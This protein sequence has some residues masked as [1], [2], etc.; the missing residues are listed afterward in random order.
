LDFKFQVR[1]AL[2]SFEERVEECKDRRRKYQNLVIPA[3]DDVKANNKKGDGDGQ[4]EDDTANTDGA[5]GTGIDENQTP[6]EKEAYEK[7]Q[8]LRRWARAIRL[9]YQKFNKGLQCRLNKAK[10][11]QLDN[12]GFD[13]TIREERGVQSEGD[14]PRRRHRKV[15]EQT[16]DSRIAILRRIHDEYGNINVESRK[17]YFGEDKEAYHK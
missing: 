16:F 4:G 13:W 5:G 14:G 12:L 6:E 7:E 8:S 1:K 3:P 11:K 15:N 10:I 17:K 9:E 2:L